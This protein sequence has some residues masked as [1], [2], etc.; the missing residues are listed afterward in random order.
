MWQTV[1]TTIALA[2]SVSVYAAPVNNPSAAGTAVF[3]TCYVNDNVSA[4]AA[5]KK[6]CNFIILTNVAVPAG[7]TLDLTGLTQGTHVSTPPPT[8]CL[9]YIFLYS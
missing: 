8:C 9:S 4:L 3:K 1:L 6:N 2:A 5:A 7:Q